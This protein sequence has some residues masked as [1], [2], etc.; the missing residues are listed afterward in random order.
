MIV[1]IFHRNRIPPR[2]DILAVI[3]IVD[4]VTES[5]VEALLCLN[6][7]YRNMVNFT[8]QVSF[9]IIFRGLKIF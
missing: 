4:F 9:L 6:P 7:N 5:D 8:D 3:E 2:A 1:Y